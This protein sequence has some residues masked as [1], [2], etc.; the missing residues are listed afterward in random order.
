MYLDE[1]RKA[2]QGLNDTLAA[3]CLT[4]REIERQEIP[5]EHE[6]ELEDATGFLM[7]LASKVTSDICER[8]IEV[9][10]LLTSLV[11]TEAAL[12]ILGADILNPLEV[13]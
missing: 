12:K 3:A 7:A 9:N 8:L 13:N 4:N 1:I 2:V 10:Y 5:L 11:E 6:G